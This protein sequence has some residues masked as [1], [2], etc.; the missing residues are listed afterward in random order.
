MAKKLK[1][2]IL[3][4][5]SPTYKKTCKIYNLLQNMNLYNN[6][7]NSYNVFLSTINAG[8]EFGYNPKEYFIKENMPERI[9][10]LKENLDDISLYVIDK[11]IEH[12]LNFPLYGTKYS[13]ACRFNTRDIL[14]NEDEIKENK[15]FISLIPEL[16]NKYKGDWGDEIIPES[17]YYHHGLKFLDKDIL[18]KIQGKSFIDVGSVFGDS[19]IV[20][21]EYNPSKIYSFDMIDNA[22]EKYF[23][24]LKLNNKDLSKF[25]FLNYGVS[26]KHEYKNLNTKTFSSLNKE[27]VVGGGEVIQL[28]L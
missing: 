8:K 24:N 12:W 6:Q 7:N 11:K 25:E 5:I 16:K 23:E 10:K 26:D 9:N 17:F 21:S 13:E 1:D 22:K 28:K 2:K 4:L 15:K 27:D 14:Y 20:L 19:A 18:N 3:S